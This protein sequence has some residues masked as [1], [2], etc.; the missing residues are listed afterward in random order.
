MSPETAHQLLLKTRVV[1]QQARTGPLIGR[2]GVVLVTFDLITGA[3]VLPG[4]ALLRHL[5]GGVPPEIELLRPPLWLS[6]AASSVLWPVALRVVDA[7][8][9]S[10]RLGAQ[11]IFTAAAV[12]ILA[13]SGVVYLLDKDLVSRLLILV[14]AALA[15]ACAFSSRQFVRGEA[16][17]TRTEIL[18]NLSLDAERSLVRGEPVS[19]DLSRI[20]AALARPTIVYE[21]GK[22]WIYPS[23]L[24]PSDRTV[25]RLLDVLLSFMILVI[26]LIPMCIIAVAIMLVDGRPIFFR[27]Q[28]AG[29]FGRPFYMRKFRSMRNGAS[30]ERSALWSKSATQGPAF[31]LTD[32]PRVTP[33]GKLLRR[34]SLDELPQLIDVLQGRMSLVGPR[35]AG[36]DE[37]ERYE[38]RHRLRLTVRPGV[39]GLWQ[40]R[41]RVD[42]DFE[43]RMSDD[44]EYIR[45]WSPLFD[46]LIV[47]RSVGAVLA[48]RGV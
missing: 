27:D 10:I 13:A 41:R 33:I 17:E 2:A 39:T 21:G 8:Y 1:D 43:Q 23:M 40:V 7:G 3:V 31:K 24:G 18:P 11:R 35:P 29:L 34:F 14:G 20:S 22:I 36:L 47:I 12:W 45:R 30:G 46:V 4:S 28:R 5:V 25:K 48:G 38:D 6:A 37:L 16:L 44:L 32:D 9:P 26:A 19:I 42:A 15:F